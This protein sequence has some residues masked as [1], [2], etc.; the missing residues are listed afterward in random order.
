MPIGFIGHGAPTNGLRQD[1]APAAWRAWGEALP[2]PRAILVI[3][4]HWLHQPPVV[5]AGETLPLIYDFYGFPEPL[6]QLRYPAPGAPELADEA[7]GL[8]QSAG[9]SPQ[10]DA[11]R[12]LDHGAWV[13][14]LHQFPAAD[15]PVVQVTAAFHNPAANL[16]LGRALAPLSRQGVFILGSGNIVHNLRLAN[17]AAPDAPVDGWAKE[18][19]DWCAAALERSDLDALADYRNLAPA[20]RLAVPTDDHFAPLLAV[21]AA[22]LESGA[23]SLRYP[24]TGFEHQ[25]LSMRCVEFA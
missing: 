10:R 22:A 3:S 8:L 2:K 5:G 9:L 11:A 7:M 20:A 6:Y 15:I 21:A 4:A 25:N 13:P 18:F 23:A 17:L 14:L 1:G 19:D 16:A 12:G 24:H